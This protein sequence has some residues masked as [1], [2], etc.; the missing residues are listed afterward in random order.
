MPIRHTE[1]YTQ[2]IILYCYQ[3][4]AIANESLVSIVFLNESYICIIL[5]SHI[6]VYIV[7][8]NS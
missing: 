2:Y 1:S 3:R 8:K 6:G 7:H 4:L 5:V